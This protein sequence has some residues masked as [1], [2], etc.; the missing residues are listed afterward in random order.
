MNLNSKYSQRGVS[1]DKTEVHSAIASI[2]KGLYPNSFCKI[3]PDYMGGDKEYCNIM[4]ADTAGTKTSLAYV[5]WRET[6]DNSVWKG[7]IQDAIVMNIDDMACVGV[8][9]NI[10]LSSTI[11]RN[12]NK[13]TGEVIKN[14]IQGTQDFLIK[15]ETLGVKIHLAGGETA[16]VGDIVR[17]LDVGFTAMARLKRDE[18]ININ[19]QSGDVIVGLS[20][21]GKA[22]Y[23]NEYNSGMGCNGLTNARHDV[24]SNY[25]AG[26][27]PESFDPSIPPGLV[28]SG[29]KKLTEI[30]NETGFTYGKLVLSPTR[31]YLPVLQ[32]IIKE[33]RP[34]IHGLIHCTG[35]GQTKVM[36][37]V[38]NLHIIKD[39]L[40]PIPPLFRIIKE[41]A[42]S[43]WDEMYQVFNMGHRMEIYVKPEIAKKII[44]FAGQFNIEA[45]VI[46]RCE[47]S[48]KNKLTIKTEHGEFVYQ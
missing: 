13:V 21:Y 10:I 35:G 18:I 26:K 44:K 23:E 31:T 39:K 15:M 1:S 16:D 42:H 38:N 22:T 28:Y 27:Y 3:L 4:H 6:G 33:L 17:T 11:G 45:K 5:Y 8:T 12:K 32:R 29:T 47:A 48:K 34:E 37:F 24:F 25:L 40:F 20:S 46:G 19:I 7:I 36:K 43:D 2:D 30:E 14:L 41:E 9:D